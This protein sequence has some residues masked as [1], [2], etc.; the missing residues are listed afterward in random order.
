MKFQRELGLFDDASTRKKVTVMDKW[1]AMTDDAR[2]PDFE[3]LEEFLRWGK[4]YR[5]TLEEI[6]D[7]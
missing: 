2:N 3:G 1:D 5:I 4:R 7:C 6:G